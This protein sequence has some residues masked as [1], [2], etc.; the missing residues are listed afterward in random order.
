[1]AAIISEKFRIFNATQFLES[2]S[3]GS[4]DTDTDRSRMYF[5]VGRP[6]EW[7]A[8]VEV[9]GVSST[10]FSV[11]EEVYV[12]ANLGASTFR[13][14]VSEVYPNS[15]LLTSIGPTVSAAPSAGANVRSERFGSSGPPRHW[16][17]TR[18]PTPSR[19]GWLAPAGTLAFARAD[20]R[21][22]RGAGGG[23]GGGRGGRVQEQAEQ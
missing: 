8:Y 20:E 22:P 14:T 12:G 3:E 9:F 2:L 4:G 21:G 7:K 17:S 23:R 5:F 13:G 19:A 15:L 11:G 18:A 16:G 6:Q 1:M 10:A